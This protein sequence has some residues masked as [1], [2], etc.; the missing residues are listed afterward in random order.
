M[1]RRSEDQFVGGIFTWFTGVVEDINDPALLNRVRVRCFGFHTQ[2]KGIV[3]TNDLPWATVMMPATSASFKG[4]GSNHELM[5]GSWV[6]GFFR[7]G[8]SAQDP[9]V[10]GSIATQTDGTLDIPEEAQQNPPMNKVHKTEAGHIVEF[11]NTEGAE[12]INVQHKSGTTINIAADGTV[13]IQASNNQ[14]NLLSNTFIDGTLNVSGASELQST[15]KVVG[16][17]ENDS[18]ITAQGEVTA[19]GKALSTHRHT[20]QG[21][22]SITTPPN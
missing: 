5:V 8:P 3:T 17:Q 18:S 6:V 20:A 15:L 9:I 11:D 22:T 10:M 21:A 4:I 19:R 2:D 7:D 12:R 14:I 13:T 16:A 1:I